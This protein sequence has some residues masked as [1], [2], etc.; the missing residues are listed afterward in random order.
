MEYTKVTTIVTHAY[1]QYDCGLFTHHNRDKI[2]RTHL[3]F[4]NIIRM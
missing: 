4:V 3:I 1:T 2:I